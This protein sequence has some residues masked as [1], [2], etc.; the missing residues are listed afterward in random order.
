MKNIVMIK[1]M[2]IAGGIASQCAVDAFTAAKVT[3]AFFRMVV[4]PTSRSTEQLNFEFN[5]VR[6]FNI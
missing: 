4:V 3:L 6:S 5:V 1:Q 2:L